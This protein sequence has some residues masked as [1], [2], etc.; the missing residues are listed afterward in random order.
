MR[1]FEGRYG[2]GL[3]EELINSYQTTDVTARHVLDGFEQSA[4]HLVHELDGLAALGDGLTLRRR[5]MHL[6]EGSI[7]LV[8]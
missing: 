1:V 7:F 8:M 2:S 6:D 4:V 5:T 3:N